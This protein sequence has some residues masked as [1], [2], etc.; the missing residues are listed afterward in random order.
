MRARFVSSCLIVTLLALSLGPFTGCASSTTITSE[1]T[2][3]AVRID[4]QPVGNTPVSFTEDSVFLWTK[5]QVTLDKKGYQTLTGQ[6]NATVSVLHL[7]IGIFC[8][9]P[10]VIVGEFK[11]QYHY[12]LMRKEASEMV[13]AWVEKAQIQFSE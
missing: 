13:Q 7:V 11:P 5:H 12:V 4:G 8:C 9:L 10:F 1:P 3:A 6:M 2:G